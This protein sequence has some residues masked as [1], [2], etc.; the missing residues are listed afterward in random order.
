MGALKG[1]VCD[2]LSS[3]SK[4]CVCD[5][6]SASEVVVAGKGFVCDT[7]SL[8]KGYV[9]RMLSPSKGFVSDTLFGLN[10]LAVDTLSMRV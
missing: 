7:L 3:L 5:T 4:G 2:T 8:V 10:V 9:W 1:V 6:L